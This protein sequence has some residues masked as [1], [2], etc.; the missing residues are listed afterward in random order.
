MEV[1]NWNAK[2]LT[3]TQSC[4]KLDLSIASPTQLKTNTPYRPPK[5]T[6]LPLDLLRYRIKEDEIHARYVNPK[7]KKYRATA[8]DLIEIYT[9]H[10]NKTKGTLA[11]A[12]AD[13]EAADINY[14]ITR[15]LAKLLED[16][17]EITVQSPIEPEMLREKIFAYASKRHPVITKSYY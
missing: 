12:L 16:R 2:V 14:H 11:S 17:S 5:N 9:T 10:L 7:N 13:Y 15:G 3:R 4:D 8:K 1:V 6:M